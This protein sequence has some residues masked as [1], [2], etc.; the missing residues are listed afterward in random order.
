MARPRKDQLAEQ[1]RLDA[2]ALDLYTKHGS[3]RKVAELQDVTLHTAQDRIQRALNRTTSPK[4][5]EWKDRQLAALDYLEE[6][7]WKVLTARHITVS[8]GKL[9]YHPETDQPLED[10][11]PVLTATATMLR[12]WERRSKLLGTDAP[13]KSTVTV[14]TED[15][16]D[17]E[18]RRLTEEMAGLDESDGGVRRTGGKAPPAP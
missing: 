17:A 6:Q 5:R 10:D 7:V 2:E 15:V 11:G 8:N 1:A 13:T 3:G 16:V 9:I 14:V 4:A 12:I 18:M